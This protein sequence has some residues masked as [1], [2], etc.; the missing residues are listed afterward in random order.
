MPT[1]DSS[2]SA[3]SWPG[4]VPVHS[5]IFQPV[6]AENYEEVVPP[7]EEEDAATKVKRLLE[8]NPDLVQ[9]IA[10]QPQYRPT[11]VLPELPVDEYGEVSPEAKFQHILESQQ[12]KAEILD[13][14]LDD[15][16]AQG[17]PDSVI[18]GY[19]QNLKSADAQ[20]LKAFYDRGAH[21]NDAK[22]WLYD[23][24]KAE[25]PKQVRQVP[26]APKPT[27]ATVAPQP[28]KARMSDAETKAM[29]GMARA[30]GV[31]PAEFAKTYAG[32]KGK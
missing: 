24:R 20:T 6:L 13:Q 28:E 30:L 22:A 9:I 29:E 16:K 26:Q 19:K 27:S 10:P 15:V 2:D 7:V 12:V 31:D 32:R 14:I 1:K 25:A 4:L 23:N 17:I 3:V 5:K 18:R 8:E 11:F 21:L